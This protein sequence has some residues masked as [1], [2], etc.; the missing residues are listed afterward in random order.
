MKD[1]TQQDRRR[2]WIDLP[3]DTETPELERLTRRWRDQGR[4]VPGIMAALKPSPDALKGV[5]RMNY[6]V[7]FGGSQLSRAREELIAA[8][9]SAVNDCFY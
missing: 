5:M 6:A 9:T 3:S 8:A 4:G 7:T 1:P 2:F